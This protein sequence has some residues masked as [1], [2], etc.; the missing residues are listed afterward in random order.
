MRTRIP[1]CVSPFPNWI[2]IEITRFPWS[3]EQ[4]SGT[5][6]PAC[7]AP[8]GHM[9]H[10][11]TPVSCP[12]HRCEFHPPSGLR[13]PQVCVHSLLC[14]CVFS[15]IQVHHMKVRVATTTV[16]TQHR[17]ITTW[18]GPVGLS[19]HPL[20]VP[21]AFLLLRPG[22]CAYV[23]HFHIRAFQKCYIDGCTQHATF[24]DWLFPLSRSLIVIYNDRYIVIF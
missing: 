12:G 13:F 8:S 5:P 16:R 18:T 2:F 20:S 11:S 9:L 14:V 3:G 22:H 17:S 4:R 19:S 10:S 24:Q 6:G 21:P 23:L 1:T 15:S 7:I